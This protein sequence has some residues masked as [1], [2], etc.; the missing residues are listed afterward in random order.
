MLSAFKPN[1]Y[2]IHRNLFVAIWQYCYCTK[3]CGVLGCCYDDC[4]KSEHFDNP[5]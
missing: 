2:G 5:R 1:Y 3:N 4:P